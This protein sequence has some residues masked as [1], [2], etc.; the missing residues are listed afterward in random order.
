MTDLAATPFRWAILGTGNIARQFA[1][2]L[3][4]L[5]HH[6]LAFV[7]S[8]TVGSG[9]SFAAE[10]GAKGAGDYDA[11][12]RSD[13]DA[14]YVATP[15][16]R[17]YANTVAALRADK[18]VLCEK[19]LATGVQA[20]NQMYNVAREADRLLMEAFMYRAHPQTD[21]IRAVVESGR[22]GKLRLIRASFCYRTRKTDPAENIRFD[23]RLAGGALMD[24]GCYCLDA[25]MMLAGGE[26]KDVEAFAITENGVD[27]AMSGMMRFKGG[28]LATFNCGLTTQADNTLHVCGD[29]GHLTVPVPWKPP[30]TRYTISHSTPPKQDAPHGGNPL[31]PETVVEPVPDNLYALEAEA[32]RA[33]ANGERRPFM[34]RGESLRLARVMAYLRESI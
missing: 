13:A 8:R 24:V 25:A 1:T 21:A 18:H 12:I 11:A 23:E 15:N 10:F 17:H 20:A 27:T 2:G 7:G 33:T 4:T 29:E 28:C 30:E 16:T 5:P 9:E 22:L 3:A 31:P 32:F 34:S 6:E 14:V 26:P 19:P